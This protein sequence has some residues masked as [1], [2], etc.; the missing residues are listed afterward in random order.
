MR[1]IINLTGEI[2]GR[3]LVIKR[4]PD[5]NKRIMWYC[6]CHCGN[7]VIISRSHL[8]SSA[9]KSCGCLRSETTINYNR[10]KITH[11]AKRNG[12]ATKE[13][14][15]WNSMKGRCYNSDDKAYKYYGGRG[16]KMCD[17]WKNSFALFLEDMG[18][19]PS[20]NYSIDRVDNNGNYELSNCRWATR[21]EQANNKRDNIMIGNQTLTQ[22]CKERNLPY[23]TIYKRIKEYGWSIEDAI[24]IPIG[25]R[26]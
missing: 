24:N 18:E 10:S 16:I 7:Q 19:R 1:K 3:L 2:V 25:Q 9:I 23:I 6:D 15:C 21:Q 11:G 12:C 5:K 14:S 17:R 22:V 26:R 8:R 20:K 13:Y 4:A